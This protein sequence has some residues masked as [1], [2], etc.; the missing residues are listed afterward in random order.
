MVNVI[1][2]RY[3][4]ELNTKLQG[5]SAEELRAESRIV[6]TPSQVVDQLGALADVGVQRLMLQWLDQDDIDG[7]EA[8]AQTV[9]PQF[10]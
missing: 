6:G 1:F 4:S 8:M 10:E 7:L 5:R 3:E 9:L 2:G